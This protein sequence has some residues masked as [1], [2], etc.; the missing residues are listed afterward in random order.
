MTGPAIPASAIVAVTP[1]VIAAG[2]SA[3]DLVGL[4]LTTNPRVPIGAALRFATQ[5]DVAAFF[6]QASQEAALGGNYFSGFDNSNV[7]PASMLWAQYNQAPVGA[8]LR[9]GSLA[10]MTLAQLQALTGVLTV[11]IDGTPHTSSAIVLSAATSFSAAAELIATALG[12][13][14]AAGASFTGSI[15][16]TVLTVTGSPTGAPIAVGQE[17]RGGTV[18]PGTIITALGTGTGG[19][20]TYTVNNTQTVISGSLTTNTPTVTYDSVAS[21]FVINSPTTGAPSTIGFGSGTIAASLALTQATGAMTSQGA[22]AA[23]PASAMASIVAQTQDWVSFSTM[24]DPDVSGNAIKLAFAQWVTT[25]NNRWVYVAWDTDVTAT[26]VSAPTSLGELLKGGNYSGTAPLYSPTNGPALAAFVMGAIASIDFTEL[27]GRTTL[28]FRAQTGITPD[29]TN[30]TIAANLESHGYNY[31][32]K[33]ATANDQFI[34]CYP[35]KISGPFDWIDSYVDQVWMN[36]QFQLAL[37]VLLTNR[38]SIPYNQQGYGLIKAACQDTIN[39]AVDFGAVRPGIT[40]SQAQIA[41]VNAD[42]GLK[43]DDVLSTRGW[44][45]QVRD[46]LPQVRQARGSPPVSFFYMD[47]GSIQKIALAS[48]MIQ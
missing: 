4:M 7:K 14:G 15:T 47:G 38:K 18:S 48:I 33:W 25:Q 26:Q 41:E 1:S 36:N 34:F 5:A 23:A 31:Y 12:V 39:Q 44:Y 19:A 35:G 9:G 8:W 11:T 13:T 27:N 45:L 28:A 21:A 30:A 42:A 2:G 43:I 22:V 40:L 29:I 24:F 10:A 6:G 3:L 17:V 46:A 16:T 37:M 32:G 20:G